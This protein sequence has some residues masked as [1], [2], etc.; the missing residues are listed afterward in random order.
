MKL[1]TCRHHIYHDEKNKLEGHR[2]EFLEKS[3]KFSFPYYG[4][5]LTYAMNMDWERVL[6]FKF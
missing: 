6:L 5:N 1:H 2:F 4:N 3:T